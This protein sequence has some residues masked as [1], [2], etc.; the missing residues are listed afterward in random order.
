MK[1]LGVTG[2]VRFFPVPGESSTVK[3]TYYRVTPAPR[4]EGE[5][6]EIPD[7]VTEAYMAL[8]WV[9]FLKRLPTAQQ[10]FPIAVALAESRAAF[11]EISSFVNAPGDRSREIYN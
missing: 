1:V 2:Q 4:S 6:L 5:T 10:P 8:A 3:F 9:E 7:F 11:R